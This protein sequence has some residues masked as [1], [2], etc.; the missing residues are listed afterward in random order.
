[1]ARMPSP[2]PKS[3][4]VVRHC[5]C[6]AYAIGN[7]SPPAALTRF[8]AAWAGMHAGDGH[9][10]C[11]ADEARFARRRRELERGRAA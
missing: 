7:L 8:E 3:V 5:S 11:S 9:A 6:G 2:Q 1:M 4:R 10:P